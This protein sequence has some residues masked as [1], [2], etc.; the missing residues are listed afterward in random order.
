MHINSSSLHWSMQVHVQSRWLQQTCNWLILSLSWTMLM[1]N[2]NNYHCCCTLALLLNYSLKVTDSVGLVDIFE[3]FPDQ[4]HMKAFIHNTVLA[5]RVGY[6][7]LLYYSHKCWSI[8]KTRGRFK[9]CWSWSFQ[10]TP[11]CTIWP[12]FGWDIWD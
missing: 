3:I 6:F 11:T 2:N 5:E 12:C 9:I 1:W 7:V 4:G 8:F 10:N